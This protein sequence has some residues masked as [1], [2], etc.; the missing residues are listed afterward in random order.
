MSTPM[1]L[2]PSDLALL[3]RLF[4]GLLYGSC[5]GPSLDRLIE[6]GLAEINGPA[7]FEIFEAR[8][9]DATRGMMLREVGVTRKGA[10]VLSALSPIQRGATR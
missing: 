9:P 7:D 2:A 3:Q 5:H 6:A 4:G 10:E 8:D 1:T